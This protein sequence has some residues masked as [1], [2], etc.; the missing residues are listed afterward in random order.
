MISSRISTEH[1]ATAWYR[2]LSLRAELASGFICVIVLTLVVGLVS[3]VAQTRSIEA[4]NKLVAAIHRVDD[5]SLRSNVAMLKA[6]RAEKDFLLFQNEFGFAEARSRYGTLLRANLAEVWQSMADFRELSSD[7]EL[8]RLT[9]A[10]ELA[11]GQ[12]EAG[13]LRLVDLY[14]ARGHVETGFEGKF[15]E[16]AREIEA[17]VKAAGHDR[18]LVDVLSLR[19]HEKNF[20]ARGID[21]DVEA[22]AKG[23][24]QFKADLAPAR[25]SPGIK[26]RRLELSS[27]YARWFERYVQTD[28]KIDAEQ[29][30]YLATAHTVEPLLAKLQAHA[31]LNEYATRNDADREAR[32]AVWAICSAVLLASLLGLAVALII[33]RSV[34]QS[35]HECLGFASRVAQGDLTTRLSPKGQS[36][37]GTLAVALN[38]MTE[39]LEER[40]T[41]QKQ[42]ENK[43]RRLNRVY[44]VLSGIN[45]LIVRVRGR[46]ELFSEACRIVIDAGGFALAY[47]CVVDPVEQQLRPAASAG[48]DIGFMEGMRD[49]MTLRDDAPQGYGPPARAVREKRA[50][51]VNDVESDPHIVNKKG[52]AARGTRSIAVL[53]LFVAGEATGALGLHSGEAGFFDEEEMK[54]L[55]ELAGDI[56]FALDHL[57]KGERLSY[58]AS[59]D[60]LT[61][62]ANRTLFLERLQQRV[63]AAPSDQ[64]GF[65]VS[66]VDVERFKT[67]NDAF[68]RQTG[69][70]LLQQIADRIKSAGGDPTRMARIGADHFAVVTAGV[71]NEEAMGRFTQER[72]AA[73]FDPLFQVGGQDL[74]ISARAGIALFPRDGEDAETLL[75]NAEAALKKAKAKGERYLFFTPEMTERIH[76][77]LSLE[78]KLRQA[79]EKEQFVLHYQPKVDLEQRRIV[80]VE[81]LIRW[82]SPELGLV[83]PLRFIP[84]LEETGLI[85]QVGS[86]ALR[87][88]SLDHRR[89]VE[90]GLEAPRVAV[91]VSPIQLRQRDFVAVVERAIIEGVAP[92]GIDL[93]ITE[94]LIMEDVQGNIE[95]LKSVRSLGVN[96]AID[97]FGTGYSSLAYLAKLPVDTLKID[98]SF[99]ITML[100]DPDTMT[101]VRTMIS[102]A[103]S[104]RLKVVAEGVD[105]EEQAKILRL[106]GC[107]QMQGYLFSKPLPSEIFETRFLA[108][109][110][111]D[112]RPVIPALP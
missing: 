33:S 20:I 105:A 89:W 71:Q 92:T 42:I 63:L 46:E 86:W 60:P 38:R 34:T 101:L 6:R 75:R 110:A 44:A 104:M 54:L 83:P 5:L 30:A 106:L 59:Y 47:I 80:G 111:Q 17:I 87:R 32:I 70:Q 72:L 91:N 27:D 67:I 39:A 13:F 76:E 43:I 26:G 9:Q 78:S 41:E 97:D 96:V 109:L 82:Q 69:D 35:V 58:L 100:S 56:A 2:R 50:V 19:R 94:S 8:I 10:V 112:E 40:I 51:V 90:A 14:G 7:P 93:E 103:Q 16:R 98:R 107:D 49:R 84:L 4:V 85:L 62:L 31:Q 12:Y 61:G 77:K 88:A 57:E 74:R 29:A 48:G 23:I 21:K 79:L 102:L 3:L 55:H 15:L 81:A 66:I 73:H 45:A 28:A 1:S 11:V 99:I 37:F 68:G 108:C 36:E 18:L 52:H 22:F 53:P 24:D 65:A 25:L 64:G 95:K